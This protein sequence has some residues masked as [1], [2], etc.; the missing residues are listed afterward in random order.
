MCDRAVLR[1]LSLRMRVVCN[2]TFCTCLLGVTCSF[3]HVDEQT[4]V[5]APASPAHLLQG[6]CVHV[7]TQSCAVSAVACACSCVCTATCEAVALK[8][9]A[10]IDCLRVA[11]MSQVTSYLRY[12]K[13]QGNYLASI[14]KVD[15][16]CRLR[17]NA[18]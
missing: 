9:L 2:H 12:H 15:S 17:H 16:L 11:S 4:A 6:A 10:C 1:V 8:G 7:R 13:W 3:L 5:V 18:C 14:C